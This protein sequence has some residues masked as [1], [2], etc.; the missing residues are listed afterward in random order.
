MIKYVTIVNYIDINTGE[1]INKK[2]LG[3]RNFREQKKEQLIKIED[4][5]YT[6]TIQ[7]YGTLGSD[8]KRVN[9]LRLL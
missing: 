3:N 6:R 1:I 8:G 4:G 9:Q 5:K 7:H 2:D